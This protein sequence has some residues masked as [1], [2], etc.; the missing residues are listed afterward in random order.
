M[1]A[2]GG[3]GG[4]WRAE[5][6]VGKQRCWRPEASDALFA[7]VP[8]R[9]PK[10]GG[11][12][13]PEPSRIADPG[14]RAGSRAKQG[15]GDPSR[16][17]GRSSGGPVEPQRTACPFATVHMEEAAP[18]R[19]P[20]AT[21]PEEESA[22][23][24]RA[25]EVRSPRVLEQRPR[26]TGEKSG[27]WASLRTSSPFWRPMAAR[28]RGRGGLTQYFKRPWG[29]GRSGSGAGGLL[30]GSGRKKRQGGSEVVLLSPFPA[31]HGGEKTL[32]LALR[33]A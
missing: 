26:G 21:V 18:H 7:H 31:P 24:L 4:R 27:S 14:S 10:Y 6:G 12:V 28:R 5:G 8:A 32:K 20:F 3:N 33:G 23:G 1:G 19:R 29:A 16:A 25:P 13:Y 17:W 30:E 15:R 11:G 22:A 2:G 9:P